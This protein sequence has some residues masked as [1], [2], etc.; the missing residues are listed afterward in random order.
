MDRSDSDP[1]LQPRES[2]EEDRWERVDV[3]VQHFLGDSERIA[4]ADAWIAGGLSAVHYN[5]LETAM[6][7]LDTMP[8]D[9]LISSALLE[10]LYRLAQ[11]HGPARLKQ[12]YILAE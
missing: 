8:S 9:R 1:R 5:V 3:K 4:E 2:L 10:R 7:D 11:P 6:V 12:L